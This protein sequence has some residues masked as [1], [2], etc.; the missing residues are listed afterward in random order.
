MLNPIIA[1]LSALAIVAIIVAVVFFALSGKKN[2]ATDDSTTKT[3]DPTPVDPTTGDSTPGDSTPADNSAL[4]EAMKR[5]KAAEDAAKKAEEA[6]N[7]AAK[8]AEEAAN[9][10]AKKA[11]EAAN[12]AAKKATEAANEAAKKVDDQET[13][14]AAE[15]EKKAEADAAAD[16]KLLASGVSDLAGSVQHLA[17]SAAVIKNDVSLAGAPAAGLFAKLKERIV[18]FRNAKAKAKTTGDDARLAAEAVT[19]GTDNAV[20][21]G[22]MKVLEAQQVVADDAAGKAESAR[23]DAAKALIALKHPIS[24]ENN[25]PYAVD[26]HFE[27]VLENLKKINLGTL[28]DT[29]AKLSSRLENFAV[30]QGALADKL[31]NSEAVKAIGREIAR[32]RE[33]L[34]SAD[35]SATKGDLETLIEQVEAAIKEI[36]DTLA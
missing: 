1:A 26:I 7:E 27:T 5:A 20:S 36:N 31:P 21:E 28:E 25:E 34:K 23:Q 29:R 14:L 32:L 13:K 15:A 6:A 2:K 22:E 18:T 16:I 11:E 35:L 4:E 33:L 3:V 12:E 19:N 10:A 24:E 8:K 9:E 17:D 30:Q